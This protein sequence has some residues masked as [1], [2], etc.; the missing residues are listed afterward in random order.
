VYFN[1]LHVSNKHVLIIRGS[2]VLIQHLVVT[3]CKW[4]S[5]MQVDQELLDLHTERPLTESV[6]T[7]CC[8][9]S[10]DLV[11]MSTCLLETCRGLK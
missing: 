1:P 3:L 7:R 2:N 9:Y 10:I 5:G 6:Y 8:I 11:M 4:P